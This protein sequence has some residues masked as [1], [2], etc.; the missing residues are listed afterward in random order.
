MWEPE[1][2]TSLWASMACYRDTFT[3]LYKSLSLYDQV[4]NVPHVS[5]LS[6]DRYQYDNPILSKHRSISSSTL[7]TALENVYFFYRNPVYIVSRTPWT[8]D[9]LVARPLPTHRKTQTQNKRTQTSIPRVGFEHTI[10]AFERAK[11]VH[12]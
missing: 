10:P 5:L 3:F 1:Y 7:A 12:A 2:L 6:H 11:L 4:T 8:G 9:Q